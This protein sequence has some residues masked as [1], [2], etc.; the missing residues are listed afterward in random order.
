ML[1]LKKNS[2][3]KRVKHL[4]L[5]TPLLVIVIV[6][7]IKAEQ[8]VYSIGLRCMR[9]VLY[10]LV[11]NDTFV[12]QLLCHARKLIKV[13]FSAVDIEPMIEGIAVPYDRVR[14]SC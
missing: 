6:E 3:A 2:G 12:T 4:N 10:C 8:M 11:S 13:S 7:K 5:F 14:V 1:K 9:D